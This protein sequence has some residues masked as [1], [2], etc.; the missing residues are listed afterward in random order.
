[1]N[2]NIGKTWYF[3]ANI[4]LF[5]IKVRNIHTLCIEIERLNM[6]ENLV[7]TYHF[8]PDLTLFGTKV[9]IFCNVSSRIYA[10]ITMNEV[11]MK[12]KKTL[13]KS[14]QKRMKKPT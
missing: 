10:Q 9:W 11:F 8:L 1:M 6:N 14:E 4:D 2:E 5:D 3:L 13:R 12:Y 7:K